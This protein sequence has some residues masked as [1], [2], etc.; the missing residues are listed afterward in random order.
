[1]KTEQTRLANR[2]VD[3]GIP[4]D[5]AKM[6]GEEM[7]SEKG[8]HRLY[9]KSDKKECREQL[10]TPLIASHCERTSESAP[11]WSTA[12]HSVFFS[13]CSDVS[14]TKTVFN[15]FKHLV[16]DQAG[17]L[18][19]LHQGKAVE[20]A[21]DEALSGTCDVATSPRVVHLELS[22]DLKEAFPEGNVTG[23]FYRVVTLPRKTGSDR[24]PLV[25]MW[26][27][28]GT[29]RSDPVFLHLMDGAD[30]VGTIVHGM[31]GADSSTMG[32]TVARQV[33]VALI[34]RLEKATTKDTKQVL[35]IRGLRPA[36]DRLAKSPGYHP[37]TKLM[38]DMACAELSLS[39]NVCIFQAIRKKGD[40][41]AF[42]REFALACF[43]YQL[44]TR[45][46]GSVW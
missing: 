13:T 41:E 26:T 35:M 29:F 18:S 42:V 34:S 27:S 36:L 14:S 16:E 38:V 33:A 44:L 3:G 39:H 12:I 32:F 31:Q 21:L 40:M 20:Q 5:L 15:E 28:S 10:L 19:K 43:Y 4:S 22:P 9:A 45:P 7:G 37:E 30:F 46:A 11:R 24:L 2:L 23:A 6:V 17:L 25:R 8:L 1:M